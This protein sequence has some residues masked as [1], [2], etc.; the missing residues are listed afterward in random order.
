MD[1]THVQLCTAVVD[2]CPLL[3]LYPWQRSWR[4]FLSSQ[5]GRCQRQCRCQSKILTWLEEQNY[6][7]VHGGAV[8][9]QNCV[10]KRLAKK[11][12]FKTLTGRKG[13]DWM[14]DGNELQRSDA[15]TGNVR[16]PTVVSRNGGV[17]VLSRVSI[18]RRKSTFR[19]TSQS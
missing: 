5:H 6:Y 8:E 17:V 9:S 1:T 13:D 16:R 4:S 10:R 3:Q 15:A 14:S 7:E 2:L 18:T 11:E 19:Q 12:C